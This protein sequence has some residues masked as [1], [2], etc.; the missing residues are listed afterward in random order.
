MLASFIFLC[1]L[2]PVAL[3]VCFLT[4]NIGMIVIPVVIV[5]IRYNDFEVLE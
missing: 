5:K 3:P 2:G 4:F 1:D